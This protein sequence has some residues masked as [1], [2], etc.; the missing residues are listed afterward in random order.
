VCIVWQ[1]IKKKID[2]PL[3]REMIGYFVGKYHPLGDTPRFPAS[4]RRSVAAV[5]W[6]SIMLFSF[7]R[8]NRIRTSNMSGKILY[9]L[10][11]QQNSNV[12]SGK[13]H[14]RR[15]WQHSDIRRCTTRGGKSEANPVSN[16]ILITSV[17]RQ[18][19]DSVMS[20]TSLSDE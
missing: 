7:E 9:G 8:N 11:K 13:P 5:G 4:R 14:S 2:V 3:A 18:S 12:L 16:V 10:L 6:P 17:L 19:A 15:D 20:V 1:R